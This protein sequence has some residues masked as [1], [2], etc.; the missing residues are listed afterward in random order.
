MNKRI[1]IKKLNVRIC[2]KIVFFMEITAL[3][4]RYL[5]FVDF[6]FH[7]LVAV[8]PSDH[9]FFAIRAVP[10]AKSHTQTAIDNPIVGKKRSPVLSGDER[11]N[12]IAANS[13]LAA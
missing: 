3:V 7:R 5:R 4:I 11:G 13:V 12:V 9:M 8:F 2:L 6:S 1:Y 10:K